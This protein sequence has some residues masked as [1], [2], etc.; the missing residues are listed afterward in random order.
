MLSSE[1]LSDKYLHLNNAGKQVRLLRDTVTVRPCGRVD[2]LL[3]YV[4]SGRCCA[5]VN[6][7]SVCA[8]EGMCILF[9][10]GER[11]E[12]SYMVNDKTESYWIH[13]TGVGAMEYL[14]G[15]RLY[16]EKCFSVGTSPELIGAI[17]AMVSSK[18]MPGSANDRVSD[19]YLAL[20]LSL[21]SRAKEFGVEKLKR[22]SEVS[23]IVDVMMRRYREN[24][25]VSEYAAMCC[26]SKSRFEHVFKETTGL[27]PIGYLFKVRVDAAVRLLENTDMSGAQIAS[28]VGFCDANYFSRVFKKIMGMPPIKYRES[29]KQRG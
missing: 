28:E 19:G 27:S 7:E 20:V 3:L 14:T 15:L 24:I 11:Q 13:F 8:G 4:V 1:G 29:K 12:Y 26:L 6:G 9:R 22:V 21:F 10:P 17:N 25:G 23:R 2:Y 5:V 16:D 18:H